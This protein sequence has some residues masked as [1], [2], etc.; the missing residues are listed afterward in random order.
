MRPDDESSIVSRPVGTRRISVTVSLV[1]LV[2]FGVT[3]IFLLLSVVPKFEQ[4]FA[5]ALPGKPLPGVTKFIITD[6]I[7]LV[8]VALGWPIL[9]IVLQRWRKSNGVLWINI[10]IVLFIFGIAIT[11]LA[12]FL[13]MVGID[14][15]LSNAGPH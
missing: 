9:C 7:G 8:F 4:I 14:V 6:R 13:P 11:V 5:D 10:G 12:L 3:T 2:L 15:G 1:A